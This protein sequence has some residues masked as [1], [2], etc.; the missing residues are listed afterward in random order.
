MDQ[1]HVPAALLG[2]LLEEMMIPVSMLS[3]AVRFMSLPL[4]FSRA[5]SFTAHSACN[6]LQFWWFQPISN[7]TA[8]TKGACTC[9][10]TGNCRCSAQQQLVLRIW[11]SNCGAHSARC[12]QVALFNRLILNKSLNNEVFWDVATCRVCVNRNF[13]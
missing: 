3:V 2:S 8:G 7:R 11:F 5:D 13:G 4:Q 10:Q 9:E 1:L 6:L 12:T